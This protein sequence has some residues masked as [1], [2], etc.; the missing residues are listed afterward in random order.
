MWTKQDNSR[1]TYS[2]G[3]NPPLHRPYSS[4]LSAQIPPKIGSPML[5][6]INRYVYHLRGLQFICFFAKVK[7]L[8]ATKS[9]KALLC[10]SIGFVYFLS[11]LFALVS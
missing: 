5:D 2:P 3:T 1:Y 11:V 10:F 4:P 6:A 8:S 9:L 7:D